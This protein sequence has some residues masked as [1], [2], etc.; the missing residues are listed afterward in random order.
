MGKVA[1]PQAVFLSCLPPL[2]VL[3]THFI[4]EKSCIDLAGEILTRQKLHAHGGFRAAFS[5]LPPTTEAL[6][7]SLHISRYPTDLALGDHDLQL[8]IAIEGA[9]EHKVRQ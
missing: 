4:L 2:Q 9:V 8:R 1:G 6:I 7:P 5:L 3:P